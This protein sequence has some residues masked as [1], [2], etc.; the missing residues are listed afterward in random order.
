MQSGKGECVLPLLWEGGR[1]GLRLWCS[2]REEC[3]LN[4][5]SFQQ[6]SLSLQRLRYRSENNHYSTFSSSMYL[7][8]S[9]LRITIYLRFSYLAVLRVAAPQTNSP[10]AK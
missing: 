9:H 4:V 5:L 1:D 8:F 2:F 6:L 7:R 10:I 3:R